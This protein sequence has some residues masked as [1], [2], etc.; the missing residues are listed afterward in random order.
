[1]VGTLSSDVELLVFAVVIWCRQLGYSHCILPDSHFHICTLWF[2]AVYQTICRQT[3]SRSVKPQTGPLVD[4]TTC[5]L[6]DNVSRKWQLAWM[7]VI[8]KNSLSASRLVRSCL[9]AVDQ[10]MIWLAASW[11]VG[12][13][14]GYLCQSPCTNMLSGNSKAP[15]CTV[16]IVS[17]Q[18]YTRRITLT[19]MKK[20]YF[21]CTFFRVYIRVLWQL[22]IRIRS[23]VCK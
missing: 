19:L 11:L 12:E 17:S 13:L 20:K 3:N 21:T 7:F 5:G 4:W 22:V 6:D 14:S 1:M 10:C 16:V 8:F 23:I 15:Y 2:C 9:V 18:P